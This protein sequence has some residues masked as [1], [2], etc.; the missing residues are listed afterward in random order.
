MTLAQK[1]KR[2]TAH[3]AVTYF[4]YY[5][6]FAM[7]RAFISVF[8]LDR[9]FS[10]TQVG[11]INAVHM[12]ASAVCQPLFSQLLSKM[13]DVSLRRFSA[14][15]GAISMV[16]AVLLC[17]VPAKMW[18][19]LPLYVLLGLFQ[20]GL[21]SLMVSIGM[22]YV[23]AGVPMNVG[24]GRGIGSFG[25]AFTNTFLGMLIVKFGS[26]VTTISTPCSSGCSSCCCSPCPRRSPCLTAR[27]SAPKPRKNPPTRCPSS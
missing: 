19:Y 23:N 13:P 16:C 10:Y 24:I 15:G 20:T 4:V 26:G 7:L 6:G 22:E 2:L 3:Y 9:G 8:L 18:T 11:I 25:Y 14:F 12:T 27:W 21:V 17:F 5:A 1:T